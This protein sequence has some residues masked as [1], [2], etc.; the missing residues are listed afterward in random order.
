MTHHPAWRQATAIA[1]LVL[2]V[3]FPFVV[4]EFWVSHIA[5]QT[6]GFGTIVLSLVFLSAHVGMLS[7]AQMTVAG[8]AGYAFAYAMAP[9]A[10]FAPLGWPAAVLLALA[11]AAA[12]GALIGLVAVRTEGVATLMIT[13]AIAMGFYYLTLQN[14]AL[15]NGFDGFTSVRAPLVLGISFDSPRPL[16]F[17]SL[18][19]AGGCY[20]AVRWLSVS[21]LGVALQALRDN[22]KRLRALG[23]PIG[24]LRV[25][26]FAIAGLIAGL[27]GLL[28]LWHNGSVSPG[29]VGITSSMDVLIAAVLGGLRHP[30]G[31]FVGAFALAVLQSFAIVVVGPDRFNTAIGLTFIAVIVFSPDGCVGLWRAFRRVPARFFAYTAARAAVRLHPIVNNNNGD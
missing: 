2:A 17:L 5:G 14:Y 19:V 22:P 31:A 18:I 27:G 9:I 12:A 21:P 7:L 25:V 8:V 23:Y 16:Y 15:F 1:A 26:A 30:I 10:D 4:N 6:L 20:Y 29:S 28:N 24:V 11:L 3:A 13:L